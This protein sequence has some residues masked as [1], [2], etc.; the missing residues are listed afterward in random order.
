MPTC[1]W[2]L[3]TCQS[4]LPVRSGSIR[5]YTKRNGRNRDVIA[6]ADV[7]KWSQRMSFLSPC[8]F[9]D[10]SY[11]PTFLAP[12]VVERLARRVQNIF[13][14]VGPV[15]DLFSSMLDNNPCGRIPSRQSEAEVYHGAFRVFGGKPDNVGLPVIVWYLAMHIELFP[16]PTGCLNAD[17]VF[18]S[19]RTILG[20]LNLW[21]IPV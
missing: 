11:L 2:I 3:V 9:E 12:I 13:V 19:G 5:I 17:R 8:F 18:V 14:V 6:E 16:P 20:P 1:S 7:N 10:F 15:L 4:S 21:S